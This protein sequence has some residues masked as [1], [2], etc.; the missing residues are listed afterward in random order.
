MNQIK[1]I[2]HR[3]KVY[4]YY[5]RDGEILRQP[6]GVSWDERNKNKDII[7][8]LQ[9]RIQQ[10]VKDYILSHNGEQPSITFV[11]NKLKEKQLGRANVFAENIEIFLSSKKD[12]LKPQSAKDFKSFQLSIDDYQTIRKITL[13][14]DDVTIPFIN[15]YVEFLASPERPK[16]SKSKGSLNDN[17]ISK[18]IDALRNYMKWIEENEIYVFPLKVKNYKPVTRYPIKIVSISIEEQR[19]LKGLKLDG[20]EAMVRDLFLFS[21]ATSL[22]YSDLITLTEDDVYYDAVTGE[23]RM[24]KKA[25]KGKHGEEYV[26][27]L[28]S[29]AVEIWKKYDFNFNRL[30]NQKFNL[31]LKKI[32]KDSELFDEIITIPVYRNKKKEVLRI[33]KWRLVG[34]HTGRR[35]AITNHITAGTSIKELMAIT[36]HTRLETLIKYLNKG[37]ANKDITE[38]INL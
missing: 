32:C 6:T 14:F 26:Q 16:S 20:T 1:E 11:R 37:G 17:T 7:S 18:R 33:P 38:R 19:S 25:Q 13:T 12:T 2:K 24:V 30:S 36:S 4:I 27:T 22:R 29:T 5:S 31:N 21:C 9:S 8:S 34:S 28:N 10:I 15:D 23:Y 3:D 35:S